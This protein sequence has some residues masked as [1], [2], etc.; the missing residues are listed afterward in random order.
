MA[1]AFNSSDPGHDADRQACQGDLVAFSS[2]T[3]R[4]KKHLMMSFFLCAFLIE[5]EIW[6]VVFLNS[7]EV[8]VGLPRL[9]IA[10]VTL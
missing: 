8:S 3:L 4:Y 5:K 1:T 10:K 9:L 6:R 7:V 2:A